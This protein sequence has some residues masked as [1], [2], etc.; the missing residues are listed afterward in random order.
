MMSII[1]VLH[2]LVCILLILVVLLQAGKGADMGATFGAGGS[3]S[4][5]GTGGAAPFLT[6]LTTIC[7]VIFMATSISLTMFSSREAK[8]SVVNSGLVPATPKTETKTT[9]ETKPTETKSAPSE[10]K[11]SDTKKLSMAGIEPKEKVNKTWSP[12]LAY[13]IGLLAT[14]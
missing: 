7:A 4:L 10:S 8:R 5:F 14:D 2:V 12:K 13:A 6:K 3:Q 11:A 9:T 1:V